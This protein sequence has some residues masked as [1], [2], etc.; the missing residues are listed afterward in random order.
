MILTVFES[1]MRAAYRGIILL[2]YVFFGFVL[3][4]RAQLDYKEYLETYVGPDAVSAANTPEWVQDAPLWAMARQGFWQ[5]ILAAASDASNLMGV[6][7]AA[8]VLGG[9]MTAFDHQPRRKAVWGKATGGG[10]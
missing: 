9:M 7:C 8:F 1:L 6:V 3:L 10:M 2:P 5:D 4:L